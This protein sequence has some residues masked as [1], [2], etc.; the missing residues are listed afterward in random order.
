M[1]IGPGGS[2]FRDPMPTS[3]DVS[4]FTPQIFGP[5]LSV[6]RF[7][8]EEEAIELANDTTYGLGAGLHSSTMSFFLEWSSS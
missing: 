6:A 1:W 5:V 7:K 4:R 3:A 8:T 2:K